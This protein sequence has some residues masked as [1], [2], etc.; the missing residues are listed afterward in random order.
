MW[1]IIGAGAIGCLWAANL[2]RSGQNVHLITRKATAMPVLR[3]QD[4]QQNTY[5][6]HIASGQQ[7]LNN[8]DP[9]LVCVKATQVKQAI[10]NQLPYIG[11]NQII[12]LM[13]NGMGCAE[14]VQT[15]LP[16]NP[17]I[18]ATTANA[19]LLK[20]PLNIE[21]TGLGSTYLG[22][23]NQPIERA[24]SLTSTLNNALYNTNWVEDIK[25]KLWLKL[26]INICIN[27]LTAIHQIN[28]GKLQKLEFQQQIA[29][30]CEEAIKVA[31]TEGITFEQQTLFTLINDVIN[32][33]A[34]NYS[35]MNRDIFYQR[36]TE[37]EYIN[38]YLLEKARHTNIDTPTIAAL[39]QQIKERENTIADNE[40]QC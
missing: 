16:H 33:T 18:C 31:K 17:I 40:R 26:I 5:R 3:Y 25:Q 12:I 29:M 24:N 27:P 2:K 11:Q 36:P 13:H 30:M 10:V 19:C 21:Q 32:A 15:L 23:Y 35:S 38:G 20:S 28:N 37:N 22:A 1:Q 6:F 14:Q 7:L 8:K 9:I 34:E 39:Y 4:A